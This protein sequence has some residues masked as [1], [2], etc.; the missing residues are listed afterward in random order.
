[1]T[2]EKEDF[3]RI[4]ICV[5]LEK[6]KTAHHSCHKFVNIVLRLLLEHQHVLLSNNN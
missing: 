1:V 5:K 4:N 3:Q 6:V 2:E